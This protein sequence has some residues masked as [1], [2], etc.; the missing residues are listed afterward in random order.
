MCTSQ[1]N[2]LAIHA[3]LVLHYQQHVPCPTQ[4]NSPIMNI[5]MLS[6]TIILIYLP[7]PSLSNS[8]HIKEMSSRIV[9]T[10]ISIINVLFHTEQQPHS[11]LK[12]TRA[13]PSPTSSIKSTISSSFHMVSVF[14]MVYTAAK[15]TSKNLL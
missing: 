6:I 4:H 13:M 8:L 10:W 1:Q 15:Y 2:Q 12:Y 7:M 3:T 11:P 9:N 5:L 14:E